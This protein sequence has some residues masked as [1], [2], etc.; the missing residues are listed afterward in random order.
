MVLKCIDVSE[1]KGNN[2][3]R[4]EQADDTL[5]D[6][7]DFIKTLIK[8]KEEHMTPLAGRNFGRKGLNF[9]RMKLLAP[10]SKMTQIRLGLF[11]PYNLCIGISIS[12]LLT[13][14]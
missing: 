9:G 11:I 8:G 5:S 6:I 3:K 4:M 1:A 7:S 2:T 12:C 14:G 10:P 13:M